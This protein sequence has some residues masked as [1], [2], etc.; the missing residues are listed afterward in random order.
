MPAELL[1]RSR[2]VYPHRTLESYHE[3]LLQDL[4]TSQEL[5]AVALQK[6]QARQAMYYNRRNA[7]RGVPFKINQLVWV[8]RPARG[9]KMTKLAHRWRGPGQVLEAAGYDNYR[10]K[11][12]DTGREL[13]TRCS[14]LLPYYYPTHLLQQMAKDIAV[15]LREEAVAPADIDSDKETDAEKSVGTTSEPG[16]AEGR[17]RQSNQLRKIMRR[18]RDEEGHTAVHI[19]SE[20]K[21][22]ED[23]PSYFHRTVPV[24]K[25]AR[26]VRSPLVSEGQANIASRTRA[27]LRQ[28]PY[29]DTAGVP[30]KDLSPG[31]ALAP[32]TA[33][34]RRIEDRIDT[35][36]GG[37]EDSTSPWEA[38]VV[39]DSGGHEVPLRESAVDD[40]R[41]R[42]EAAIEDEEPVVYVFAGQGRRGADSLVSV[43]PRVT[44]IQSEEVVVEQRRR[45]YR[46][47]TGRYALESEVQI[48]GAGRVDADSDKLWINQDDY[49]QL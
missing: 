2:L 37:V 24:P 42:D 26:T 44:R 25:R 4:K 3:M 29:Q 38:E 48:F 46:T 13:I 16:V 20:R 43:R 34:D 28:A 36:L 21:T 11:V 39:P 35:L 32:G 31:R 18:Q 30:R 45:R 41:G 27:R 33:L 1:R 7:R 22:E 23:E 8:Y 47:R 10:V 17:A 5:T 14:F 40:N 12:L 49:E 15:N 9:A 19:D 6:E